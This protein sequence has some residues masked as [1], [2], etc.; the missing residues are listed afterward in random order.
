[1][2]EK[3]KTVVILDWDDTLFPT[4][5]VSKKKINLNDPRTKSKYA[6]LFNELDDHIYKTLIK[7]KY[8]GRCVIVTNA[9]RKWVYMCTV[10]LPKT[11]NILDNDIYILSARDKY[12]HKYKNSFKWKKETF[13]EL[14]YDHFDYNP[15]HQNI[16]SIG[17]AEY[18]HQAL[19]ELYQLNY[20]GTNHKYLKS[21]RMIRYPDVRSLLSQLKRL[22]LNIDLIVTS[23]KHIEL[24]FKKLG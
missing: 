5:W 16:V 12:Q 21:I 9:T 8:Y 22:Y 19:V 13:K 15:H 7:F 6:F 24:H 14:Y 2:I 17:D 18:E 11:A 20:N 23:T 10:V 3:D 1:M 4:S